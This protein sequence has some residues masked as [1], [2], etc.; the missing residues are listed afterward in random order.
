MHSSTLPSEPQGSPVP[1]VAAG[2]LSAGLISWAIGAAYTV[3]VNPEVRFFARGAAV[4]EAWVRGLEEA[5]GAKVVVY[6]GSSC[7]VTVDGERMRARHGLAVA[8]MGLGAGMGA[9]LLTEYAKGAVGPGDT[10]VVALEPRLLTEPMG[11]PALGIQFAVATGD[12]RLWDLCR[13]ETASATGVSALL[14]L[15]PGGYHV[16]TLLGKLV[17]GQPMYRYAPSEFR[18]SGW[19]EVTVRREVSGPPERGP[20]L[21]GDAVELLREVRRWA[22]AKGVRVGYALPWGYCPAAQ[23]DAVRR[24]NASFLAEVAAWLPVLRDERLG[25][26]EVREEFAD[27]YWHLTPEGAAKRTD[28]LADQIK[29]W[30][31]WGV[32]DL[33]PKARGGAV[34][35]ADG[36]GGGEG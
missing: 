6:G 32:E 5:G 18:P 14:A 26:Y 15:R 2:L 27:T 23:L 13:Q 30:E 29:R 33:G 12:A 22:E 31:V 11:M 17:S 35:E 28:A 3:W 9:R 8:N 34:G 20:H 4:K 19:Q 21:S 25:A 7:T 10:L 16:F 36:G 1:W 24:E